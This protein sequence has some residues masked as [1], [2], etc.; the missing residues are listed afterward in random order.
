M[1]SIRS[2]RQFRPIV[3]TSAYVDP[4]SVVIG[5]VRLA[6]DVSIWPF[7]AVRGDVHRIEIGA[8]SN[9][10]DHAC[11]HVTHDGPYTPGGVPLLIGSDV[12]IGHGA[13]LHACTVGDGCLIG[14][15]V[16]VL[17]G[18]IVGKHCMVGAGSLVPP[19]K[20]L[21]PGALYLGNPVKLVRYL[22]DQEIEKLYYSARNYVKLKDEYLRQADDNESSDL[23]RNDYPDPRYGRGRRDRDE[24]SAED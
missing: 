22:S 7:A 15:G 18:A 5:R 10:Q 12:T 20:Q 6:E 9:V 3:A 16:I 17:D 14:M 19:G 21:S 23:Y 11:L 8:R 13:I 4:A 24:W 2:Y 1:S